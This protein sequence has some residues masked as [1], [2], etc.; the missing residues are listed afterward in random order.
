MLIYFSL[1]QKSFQLWIG[2]NATRYHKFNA[3]PYHKFMCYLIFY[4]SLKWIGRNATC[5]HNFNVLPHALP[6][7]SS[8]CSMVW[9]YLQRVT[10]KFKNKIVISFKK[11]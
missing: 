5:Y 8:Q 6:Y 3:L 9:G 2:H 10:I 4:L 7:I 11:K 1:Y